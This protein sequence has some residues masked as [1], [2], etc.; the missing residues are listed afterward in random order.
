MSAPAAPRI[1][2]GAVFGRDDTQTFE[3]WRDGA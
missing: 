1:H 3:G 2:A